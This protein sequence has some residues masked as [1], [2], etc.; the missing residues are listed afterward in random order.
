MTEGKNRVQGVRLIL[1]TTFWLMILILSV[2]VAAAWSAR[3]LS[4]MAESLHTL[5]NSFSTF[6]SF[7]TITAYRSRGPSVYSHGKPEAVIAFGLIAFLGFAGL[8]LLVISGQQL[9]SAT[10]GEALIFPVRVSGSLIQ[11]LGVIVAI[12]LSLA[13][14][15]LYQG[16]I[17]GH[18]VLRFNAGQLFKDVF[19]TLLVM[20][21]LWGV[22]RGIV[23]LDV[24]LAILMVLV[25]ALSCWQVISWQFP[26]M[27][28]QN[29]IAPEVLAQIARQVGGVT[30]CY[31]IRSRGLVGRFVQVQMN[32][33]VHSDLAEV[34]SL[35]AQRIEAVIQERYGP[36]Q[37]TFYIDSEIKKTQYLIRSSPD[38]E[39]NESSDPLDEE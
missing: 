26:F 16:R 33:I 20:G 11:L 29:A 10:Q 5:L 27:V 7:L 35:I 24:A 3:S 31:R 6:L 37:V 38:L 21:G 34:T 8:N 32:L 23:W 28:E 1:F 36:V 30:H 17:I 15:G 4:L 9:I 18:P 22:Q 39:A 14:L 13:I 19:L 25:A 2:K 12:S